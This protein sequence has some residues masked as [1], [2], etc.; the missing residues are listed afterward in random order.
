MIMLLTSVGDDD[1]FSRVMLIFS[2]DVFHFLHL[3][4]SEM[5]TSRS[6]MSNELKKREPSVIIGAKMRY[7][8]AGDVIA[9]A[10]ACFNRRLGEEALVNN[11]EEFY[12]RKNVV[13][14][15]DSSYRLLPAVYYQHGVVTR[16][17]TTDSRQRCLLKSIKDEQNIATTARRCD[18]LEVLLC[19]LLIC[20]RLVLSF[21]IEY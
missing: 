9:A 3:S 19:I 10:L 12:K 20:C 18:K 4:D 21:K 11:E 17:F 1:F 2:R 7:F 15:F 5:M 6:A 14:S 13:V 16:I 8:E